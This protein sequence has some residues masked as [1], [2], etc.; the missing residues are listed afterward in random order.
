MFRQK[1]HTKY[2]SFVHRKSYCH[3]FPT[4]TYTYTYTYTDTCCCT[5]R[6]HR[7]ISHI[8]LLAYLAA[9]ISVAYFVLVATWQAICVLLYFTSGGFTPCHSAALTHVIRLKALQAGFTTFLSKQNARFVVV[10]FASLFTVSASVFYSLPHTKY[11][12][13]WYVDWGLFY[14]P[15]FALALL[16]ILSRVGL[17]A[18]RSLAI[19][20]FRNF[21]LRIFYIFVL[22]KRS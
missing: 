7:F 19:Y 2:D 8:F 21:F 10:G 22:N 11:A 9:A 12:Y 3:F 17:I 5:P 13:A 6:Q 20:F 4:L 18:A 14:Y 16:N 15:T 1:L